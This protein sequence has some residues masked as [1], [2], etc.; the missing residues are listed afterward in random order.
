M[1]AFHFYQNADVSRMLHHTEV[2][3]ALR[4]QPLETFQLHG[5]LQL[6]IGFGAL[7]LEFKLQLVELLLSADLIITAGVSTNVAGHGRGR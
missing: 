6:L 3:V 4:L 5:C 1:A 2:P 7:D